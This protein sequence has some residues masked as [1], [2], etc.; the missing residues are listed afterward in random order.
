MIS[1]VKVEKV[2]LI[3]EILQKTVLI[4][5]AE[6]NLDIKDVIEL[7]AKKIHLLKKFSEKVQV[8]QSKIRILLKLKSQMSRVIAR[9]IMEI[10]KT[11]KGKR[12][13]GTKNLKEDLK[14]FR[15]KFL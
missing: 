14:L 10:Q 8:L 7:R 12:K 9:E 4:N 5:A 6:I 11:I 2:L 1:T 13:L 3:T 15:K